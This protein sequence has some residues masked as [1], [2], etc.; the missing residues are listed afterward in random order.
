MTKI[1]NF[2]APSLRVPGSGSSSDFDAKQFLKSTVTTANDYA[3]N[4]NIGL[5]YIKAK[6][7]QRDYLDF[8]RE[9]LEARGTLEGAG[10][11]WKNYLEAN[12]IFKEPTGK[13]AKDV[14]NVQLNP[15][16]MNWRDW[17][18]QEYAPKSV[19]RDKDGNLVLGG[20]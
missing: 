14:A 17:F 18:R 1:S 20:G 12:K 5:G 6:E 7:N 2:I 19:T 8:R 15:N 13:Q 9:Y 16:R 4:R 11:Y 10:R 3:V